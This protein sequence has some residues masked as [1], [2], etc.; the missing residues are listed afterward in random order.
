MTSL[1]GVPLLRAP[2]RPA[3][4][5]SEGGPAAAPAAAEDGREQPFGGMLLDAVE[6]VARYA[7]EASH[8]T[9]AL[10]RGEP[11]EPHDL[12][13]ALSKSE[14]A[15]NLMLEVRNKLIEAWQ[16]LSRQVV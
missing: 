12:M 11:L 15:F 8:K 14:V 16:T 4:L 2:A 1:D 3:L 9:Q 5:G 6:E 10:A 13:I 7:Q